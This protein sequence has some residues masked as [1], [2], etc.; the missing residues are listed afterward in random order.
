MGIDNWFRGRDNVFT[1]GCLAVPRPISLLVG[2]TK[3]RLAYV[4]LAPSRLTTLRP[5][6]VFDFNWG[7]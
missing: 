4:P 3:S 2:S 7:A 6:S 1:V 5:F